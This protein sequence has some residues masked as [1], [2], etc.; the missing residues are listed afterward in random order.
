MGECVSVTFIWREKSVHTWLE[1]ICF[2]LEVECFC[3][4]LPSYTLAHQEVWIN[5]GYLSSYVICSHAKQV[6]CKGNKGCPK[7]ERWALRQP[8]QNVIK[9]IM[10]FLKDLAPVRLISL[11]STNSV[12]LH[13]LSPLLSFMYHLPRET[14]CS[15]SAAGTPVK[16]RG[17]LLYP[18]ISAV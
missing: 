8:W 16:R 13:V 6:D 10:V 5:T 17:Y 12:A 3:A 14:V 11:L 1:T 7:S 15:Q 2:S 9:L 4:S 18:H